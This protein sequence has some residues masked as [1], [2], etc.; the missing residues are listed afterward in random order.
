V[1]FWGAHH[2]ANVI[3]PKPP[4]GEL[5]TPG[6]GIVFDGWVVSAGPV[7]VVS[8]KEFFQNYSKPSSDLKGYGRVW[9]E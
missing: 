4:K 7:C 9:P 6:V 5:P 1:N 8:V 3:Y 2:H